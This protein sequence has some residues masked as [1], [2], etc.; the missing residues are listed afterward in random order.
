MEPGG[1]AASPPAGVERVLYVLEGRVALACPGSP[2]CVLEPGGFA[3]CPPAPLHSFEALAPSRLN[4]FE[5]RY[6]PRPDV[7]LPEAIFGNESEVAGTPFLGD[8]DAVLKVLLPIDPRFDL[9]V[10]VFTFQPGAALPL[11]EMHVME[12][13]LLMLEGQ[14]V[15]RLDEEWYPVRQGDV[16]WMAPVLPAV[17]RRDGQDP[18]ALPLLQGR[19]PRPDGG[20]GVTGLRLDGGDRPAD[21]RARRAGGSQRRSRARRHPRRLFRRRSRGACASSRGCSETR[22]FRFARMRS[23]TRSRAG[24]GER[25][26]LSAVATGSHIDAIPHSGRFD[27]TVGVLGAIEA[28]RALA[29]A[30]FRPV[31]PIEIVLFTSEEPT[32]FGIGCLGSRGLCGSLTATA[33]AALKDSEGNTLEE[34]RRAAGFQGELAEVRLPSDQY[35]RFRRAAHRAR[36]AARA[37]AALPIGIVTAIAAP[38]ALRVTWEGE[39]GHAG[40][41][42]MAGR[43]DALCAAAEAVL[44]V[45]ALGALRPAAPT[46]WRRRVSAGCTPARSTASPTG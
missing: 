11:V 15:Y 42:L 14:G 18:R 2:E 41:V 46:P 24:K 43:R 13:G 44:A 8:P 9:A 21:G 45:E 30:G 3:Y 39:G 4:I 28:V 33:L 20:T 10:N 16:I 5:K 19:E 37:H 31:R 6:V 26:E 12:H 36:P 22:A 35:R 17:V 1:R 29:R 38:A 40:A 7:P 32:R 27:G 25:P 34:L 23:E